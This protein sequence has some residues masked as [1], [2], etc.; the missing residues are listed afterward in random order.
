LSLGSTVK[1]NE[2]GKYSHKLNYCHFIYSNHLFILVLNSEKVIQKS[3][4]DFT[5]IA[6]DLKGNI[7]EERIPSDSSIQQKDRG[8]LSNKY[9]DLQKRDIIDEDKVLN[10]ILEANLS[11]SYHKYFKDSFKNLSSPTNKQGKIIQITE[12]SSIS[13]SEDGD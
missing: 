7:G 13:N 12:V 11:H 1:V 4:D 8:T 2:R 3:Q 10:I 6:A 9:S 5:N